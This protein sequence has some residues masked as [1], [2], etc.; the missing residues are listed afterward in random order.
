MKAAPVTSWSRLAL[1][2]TDTFT[3]TW[4]LGWRWCCS[5]KNFH[6][7]P[8]PVACRHPTTVDATTHRPLK[9]K[10]WRSTQRFSY[11]VSY[12]TGYVHSGYAFSRHKH[13]CVT[14]SFLEKKCSNIGTGFNPKQFLLKTQKFIFVLLTPIRNTTRFRVLVTLYLHVVFILINMVHFKR[15]IIIWVWAH[16]RECVK[17]RDATDA[18]FKNTY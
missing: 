15:I 7:P 16:V 17:P 2:E 10:R 12:N 13:Q 8:Q 14:I 9:L 5:I 11:S 18:S 4:T 6:V 1:M 3:Y